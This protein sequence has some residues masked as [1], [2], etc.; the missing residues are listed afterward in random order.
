MKKFLCGVAF[1][2]SGC[3]GLNDRVARLESQVN[4]LSQAQVRIDYAQVKT[5]S[6]IRDNEKK[7]EIYD[8]WDFRTR[9]SK[10]DAFKDDTLKFRAAHDKRWPHLVVEP[11]KK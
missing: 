7:L 11:V 10:L 8:I 5:N 6:R 9:L 3:A 1:L 2:L 4:E